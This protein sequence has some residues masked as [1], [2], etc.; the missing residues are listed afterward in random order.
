MPFNVAFARRVGT[1][2]PLR[3]FQ[4]SA[5]SREELANHLSTSTDEVQEELVDFL[6]FDNAI[7]RILHEISQMS[8]Y[9]TDLMNILLTVH[10]VGREVKSVDR[11]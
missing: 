10:N 3:I 9:G 7:G 6:S 4:T 8:Y 5:E 2:G 11:V 1:T